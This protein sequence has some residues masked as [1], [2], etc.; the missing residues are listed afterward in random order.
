MGQSKL[1]L[2][3]ALN[4]WATQVFLDENSLGKGALGGGNSNIFYFRFFFFENSLGDGFLQIFLGNF[5]PENWV[6]MIPILT[7]IFFRWVETTT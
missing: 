5:H 4:V 3:Q 7:I 1:P 2:A 6:K